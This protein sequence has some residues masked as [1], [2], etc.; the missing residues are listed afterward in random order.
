[1]EYYYTN[2]ENVDK[3]TNE[4]I[5]KDFEYKHL[6]KVLRKREGDTIMVTDGRLNLYTCKIKTIESY[7]IFCSI[8]KSDYNLFEPP[9]N[10]K[11]YIAPLRNASRFEFAIEKA[12]ELGVKIIQPVITEHTIKEGVFSK[13]KTE[14]LNKIIIGAMGQ[15]QRCYLPE[16]KEV[17]TFES[18]L[19]ISEAEK[20]KTVMY[21]Y[22]D[23]TDE[24]S[25]DES[26]KDVSLFIGPEGGF[27]ESE[28]NELKKNHWKVKSL[29]R[30]KLR[31][32][33]AVIV[34]IYNVLKNN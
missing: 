16:L 14:R 13:S 6:V 2:P 21:E 3:K 7:V 25:I 23:D 24:T 29:G 31:A 27:S 11:L 33:T 26:M 10:L 9:V 28:I 5:I 18:L 34:S 4:L 15:S 1:M 8:I 32:E 20:N 12:V 30:R 22:S 17:I 19:K